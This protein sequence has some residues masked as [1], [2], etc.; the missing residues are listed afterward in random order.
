ML[1]RWPHLCHVDWVTCLTTMQDT[2][3][4]PVRVLLSHSSQTVVRA[5]LG[6]KDAEKLK[7]GGNVSLLHVSPVGLL[8]SLSQTL[9]RGIYI[10]YDE[11]EIRGITAKQDRRGNGE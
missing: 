1:W 11:T 3:R 9:Q 2:S 5:T 6:R 7:R 10:Q 8:S 4:T